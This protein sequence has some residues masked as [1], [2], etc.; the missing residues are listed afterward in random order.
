MNKNMILKLSSLVV[1]ALIFLTSSCGQKQKQEESWEDARLKFVRDI[2]RMNL[3]QIPGIVLTD[4][5]KDD[6]LRMHEFIPTAEEMNDST[7]FQMLQMEEMPRVKDAVVKNDF[8]T[9]RIELRKYY[10]QNNA[11]NQ[12]LDLYCC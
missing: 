11:Q 12:L 9:A 6:W 3:S 4:E 1:C 7:F 8:E 10:Q 2:G 5:E